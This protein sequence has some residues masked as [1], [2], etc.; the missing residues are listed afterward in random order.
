MTVT[1]ANRYICRN[2][3]RHMRL[4]LLAV[5]FVVM[6]GA[7]RT[8]AQQQN[9]YPLNHVTYNE[10][11]GMLQQPGEQFHTSVRPYRIHELNQS[12]P[13]DSL[14]HV[15]Y[16]SGKFARTWVGRKMVM[17]NLVRVDSAK[18][19]V[20]FDPVFHMDYGYD[21][22]GKVGHAVNTRGFVCSGS[23]GRKLSFLCPT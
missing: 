10:F 7:Q 21:L 1:C 12:I 17:E 20:F 5:S 8:L 11:E 16:H 6:I 4:V 18:Y 14:R 9:A 15:R 3:P 22:E 2:F 19:Q 23:I 13:F